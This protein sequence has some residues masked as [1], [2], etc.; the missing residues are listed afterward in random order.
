[1]RGDMTQ[2]LGTNLCWRAG[3]MDWQHDPHSK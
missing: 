1:M 2:S 3:V